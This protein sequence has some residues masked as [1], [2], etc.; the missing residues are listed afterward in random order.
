M[1]GKGFFRSNDIHYIDFGI[2]LQGGFDVRGGG[3]V[4]EVNGHSALPL[5]GN[6]GIGLR[7]ICGRGLYMRPSLTRI[8][9]HILLRSV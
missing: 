2:I 9:F 4:G 1:Y 7:E 6:V 5:L 8:R 3:I